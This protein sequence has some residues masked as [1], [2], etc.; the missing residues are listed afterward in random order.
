MAVASSFPA[1][2]LV[3]QDP[4]AIAA[5]AE[6]AI[7]G[8]L[9]AA[10]AG[11]GDVAALGIANQTETFVVWD[12]AT[13]APVHPAIVW[14]DRRTDDVCAALREHEAARPRAHRA[15]ARRDLPG[16]EAAL[17]A[18]PRRGRRRG[19]LAYGD[20]ASWLLHRLGGVHV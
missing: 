7:A 20:V 8:A 13:G 10:G 9:A 18:R 17:G 11:P 4:E 5:S 15:R 19:T 16:D 14:Q 1:P 3:E 6:R 12:R 2:G